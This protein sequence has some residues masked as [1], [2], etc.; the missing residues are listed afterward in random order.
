MR[1]L[2]G[3][4]CAAA[5]T[6]V[7]G[8]SEGTSYP[9]A[10]SPQT[11][12]GG[13]GTFDYYDDYYP[14]P[15][16]YDPYPPPAPP[17][18]PMAPAFVI[19]PAAGPPSGG[20]LV[21]MTGGPFAAGAIVMFGTAIAIDAAVMDPATIVATTPPGADG[22]VDVIVTNPDGALLSLPGGFMYAVAP[23]APAVTPR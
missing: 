6:L 23:V 13:A 22:M 1:Y 4:V 20:T 15:D 5:V 17:A 2:T 9:S 10:P 16:P 7:S 3:I 8:C 18:P 19:A 14:L 21:T 12:G 11:V